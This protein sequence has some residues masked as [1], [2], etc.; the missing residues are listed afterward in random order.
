M[1]KTKA[2]VRGEWKKLRLSILSYARTEPKITPLT[3]V[4]SI[5]IPWLGW[6]DST[7]LRQARK[8]AIASTACIG[9]FP[10]VQP[11]A[12]LTPNAHS[13][14]RIPNTQTGLQ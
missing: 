8:F 6:R 9:T 2:I 5:I 3:E 4:K 13:G 14:V 1:G 12:V 7:Y 10:C 11:P